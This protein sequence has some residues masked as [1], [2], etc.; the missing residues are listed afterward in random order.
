MKHNGLGHNQKKSLE[1]LTAY[2]NSTIIEIA[3]L[4][5]PG[6]E[7]KYRGKQYV[8]TC[9]SF[10]MLEERGLIEKEGGQVKWHIKPKS[11]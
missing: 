11:P 4:L 3:K 5:F 9:R 7:V 8:S 2:P 6:Q 1:L 10:H